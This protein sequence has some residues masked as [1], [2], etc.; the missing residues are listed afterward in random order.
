MSVINQNIQSIGNSINELQALLQQHSDCICVCLTE[1]WKTESQ[2]TSYGLLGYNLAACFCRKEEK[3]HGGSAV[4]VRGDLWSRERG[5]VTNMSV[6]EQIECCCCELEIGR[7]KYLILS[8]YRPPN[9]KLEIFFN[10]LESILIKVVNEHSNIIMSG[11]FNIRFDTDNKDKAEF[12]SLVNS[13]NIVHTT[14]EPTR[15]TNST[16]TCIDNILTNIEQHYCTQILHSLISDHSAQKLVIDMEKPKV[17]IVFKRVFSQENKRDFITRLENTDWNGLYDIDNS[18]VNKQWELFHGTFLFH[19]NSSFPIKKQVQMA[20]NIKNKAS[21]GPEVIE[22]KRRLDLLYTLCNVNPAYKEEYKKVKKEYNIKLVNNRAKLY[23]QRI[24]S[25]DDKNKCTWNIVNEIKGKPNSAVKDIKMTGKPC[26]IANEINNFMINAP[27]ILLQQLQNVPF[28]CSITGCGG[29]MYIGP[30]ASGYVLKVVENFKNKSSSGDD[31]VPMSVVKTCIQTIIDPLTHII[32]N[33]LRCGIFPNKLK[34]AL[35]KPLLK[36]G[37]ASKIENYRPISILVSF[38]K[39]F[40]KIVNN[41]LVHWLESNSIL[42]QCQHGYQKGRSTQTAIFEFVQNVIECLEQN[43]VSIGTFLDMSK[44]YDCLDHDILLCKMEKYGIRGPVLK[45]FRSYLSNR[46]QK[47]VIVRNGH[48]VKSSEQLLEQG[49]PQG[50]TISPIL[51][52]IYMNDFLCNYNLNQ[53]NFTCYADDTNFISSAKTFPDAINNVENVLKIT[54]N[55]FLVNKLVLNDNKTNF[56]FFSTNHPQFHKPWEV[57]INDTT[58]KLSKCVNFLGMRVDDVL[59]WDHHIQHVCAKLSSSC[60][61]FRVIAKYM[62]YSALRTIYH[63]LVESHIRYGIVFYGNSRD[64]NKVFIIQKRALKV[65][66]KLNIRDSCRKRFKN[67]SILT[68]YGIYIQECLMFLFK[69]QNYFKELEPQTSYGTRNVTSY[70]YPKHRL[71]LTEKSTWYDCIKLY[72][73]LPTN[74]RCITEVKAFRAEIFKLLVN[75][76]PYSI[77]EYLDYN[78]NM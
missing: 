18:N 52:I 35:V 6:E 70:N 73:K 55:W 37:D 28:S 60:Y 11:D 62:D 54:S 34:V 22:C 23:Q 71:T 69:N 49:V 61:S 36:K 26:Q 16:K 46:R 39:I 3:R 65:L 67:S 25:S 5:D 14:E 2:L 33:S 17:Q 58:V 13:F 66:W 42:N 7:D 9:G 64:A 29:S 40:E 20:K 38:S 43:H 77:R 59:C 32:N 1:H 4:Y 8:I 41:K 50:S 76:E 57:K 24:N 74:I 15:I 51:F 75:I 53:C 78:T 31:D 12:C 10:V 63:A 72:N 48:V 44:A 56:M 27:K 19:F 47:V 21:S 68:F 45:W 30:V